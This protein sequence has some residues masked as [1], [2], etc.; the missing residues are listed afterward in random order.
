MFTNPQEY[1]D[2]IKEMKSQINV[3][4]LE[5]LIL[6]QID[7]DTID[8]RW[9]IDNWAHSKAHLYRMFGNQLR[10]ET[11]VDNN[12]PDSEYRNDFDSFERN[13]L[14]S[15]PRTI[16]FL[17]FIR[18]FLNKEEVLKNELTRDITFYGMKF[19]TGMKISRVISK[20]VPADLVDQLQTA[21]SMFLQKFNGKG[22]AVVS[23][24]PIDYLTMS[25]NS[26]GWRSCHALDG[27]YRAGTLAYML[28]EGSTIG[29]VANSKFEKRYT[30][31]SEGQRNTNT[32][33]IDNKSWRQVVLFKV[34]RYQSELENYI[35][36]A[37][38]SRQYPAII[39][40][41]SNAVSKLISECMSKYFNDIFDVKKK[42]NVG[43]LQSFQ[44]N[45]D[46]PVWYN[47][48][49]HS[50]F[51][52]GRLVYQTN[53]FSDISDIENNLYLRQVVVGVAHI[54]CV[55]GC[56]SEIQDGG[57]FHGWSHDDDDY[58]DEDEE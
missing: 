6:S 14:T 10:I 4:E 8:L 15:Q 17:F 23:I 32:M 46:N 13:Y 9:H 44:E 30:V 53:I 57:R 31:W 33:S 28:D 12:V 29:Y 37:I 24:H 22:R 41:Y 56:G 36:F 45:S 39:N 11:E 54:K 3:I 25:E 16:L 43:L 27:E 19:Q 48:I 7:G 26:N 5:K 42:I 58:W 35:P 18:N 1:A 40:A 49:Y 55:C 34:P 2:T 52:Y 20:L 51:E 21:Y 38:Q 50:S 47:D